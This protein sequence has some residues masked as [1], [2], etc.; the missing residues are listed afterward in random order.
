M[1]ETSV[2]VTIELRPTE[3]LQLDTFVDE[4]LERYKQAELDDKHSRLQGIDV[5]VSDWD[6]TACVDDWQFILTELKR[7]EDGGSTNEVMY[8]RS[9]V[10]RRLETEVDSL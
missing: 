1:G 5:T 2:P 3:Q 6:A 10:L 9:K 7:L 4:L 8:F